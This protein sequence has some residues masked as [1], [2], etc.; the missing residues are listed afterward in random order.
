MTFFAMTRNYF[1]LARAG[2]KSLR[3]R[4]LR[5]GAWTIA[6]HFVSQAL[7]LAS[8]LIMTRLLLPEMFGIMALAN[9][10]LVGI[11]LMSDLGL[12]LNIVQSG[13]GNDRAF[14]DT[15]WTVQIIRG[16]LI[17]GIALFV[18]LA[19]H[20]AAGTSWLPA[21][22][23][24]AEPVLPWIIAVISFNAVISGFESTKL[25]TASRDL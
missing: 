1:S 3:G 15:I 14:L 16:V 13:R 2:N 8:N 20:F 23:V 4:V 6:G 25:A 10:I 9:V 19:L 18:G 7:R 22:S 24:Y 21:S 11:Q 17:W 12:R 5:A